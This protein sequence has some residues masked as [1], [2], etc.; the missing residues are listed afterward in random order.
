[1]KKNIII[2][3]VALF[4]LC[5]TSCTE[6]K[7]TESIFDTEKPVVDPS[8]GTNPFDQW[9]YDNFVVPYNTQIMYKF[10]LPASDLSY[11][12]TPADYKKSQLLANFIKYL[13]YDVYNKYGETDANGKAIFMKKYGPRIFHF[14]GSIAYDPSNES[15]TQGYASGGVKIT[16]INVNNMQTVN[17]DPETGYTTSTFNAKD[18][19]AL[20]K[21]QFHTMHHEFS[22]IMHQT[23]VFPVA[24]SQ[25]TP[26]AF[27]PRDWT[28]RDSITAHE[29]GFTTNYASKSSTE[30]FVEVLSCAI[31]DTDARWM[32]TIIECC[33]NGGLMDGDKERVY[34]LIDSLGI[35]REKIN[36]YVSHLSSEGLRIYKSLDEDGREIRNIAPDLPGKDR[37]FGAGRKAFANYADFDQFL[38]A[39]EIDHT[40]EVK[41]MNALLTKFEI[42]T[43]WYTEEFGLHLFE[44]RKE[45]RERQNNINEF[46]KGVR[47]YDLG[48][49]TNTQRN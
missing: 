20:N 38:A 29:L 5:S 41:G 16:L 15:E 45:V 22:H 48:V 10:S 14:I 7:F 3:I 6:D 43:K 26:A 44:I 24:F 13:F 32:N 47:I 40:G 11:Q 35:G 46:I 19:E 2:A 9:L 31:T 23:K 42:A 12:L 49:S 4:T 37:D 36:E 18:I 25:I 28:G 30:D 8:L 39:Q 1:M 27:E 34:E 33:M 17:T 21:D